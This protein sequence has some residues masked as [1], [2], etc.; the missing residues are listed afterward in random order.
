[1]YRRGK[2]VPQCSTINTIIVDEFQGI[3]AHVLVTV[4][5]EERTSS[6]EDLNQWLRKRC[7]N[8]E[9]VNYLLV[10]AGMGG[11]HHPTAGMYAS[12]NWDMSG[13]M[14]SAILRSI[15]RGTSVPLFPS[16]E[17]VKGGGMAGGGDVKRCWGLAERSL[18]KA[19]ALVARVGLSAADFSYT[20]Y[21][22]RKPTTIAFNGKVSN[23]KPL[24]HSTQNTLTLAGKRR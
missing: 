1:M 13:L 10:G 16:C 23:T 24:R 17:S 12:L 18:K 14:Q 8:R 22:G 2:K 6:A 21:A 15:K 19:Y 20:F 4:Y 9:A 5:V 11:S 3:L 7:T